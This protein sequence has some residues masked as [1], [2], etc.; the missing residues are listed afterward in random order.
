MSQAL[1]GI[2]V[3]DMTHNQAGPA[4][5]CVMSITRMPDRAW[6]MVGL[7]TVRAHLIGLPRLRQPR[8]ALWG[9]AVAHRRRL[10][11]CF[12][13]SS[14]RTALGKHRDSRLVSIL[15]LDHSI[16]LKMRA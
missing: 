10:G 16:R 11:R 1:S 12:T 15:R 13:A 9:Q 4:W 5:L 2:R 8:R 6:L 14:E 7:P 3:I